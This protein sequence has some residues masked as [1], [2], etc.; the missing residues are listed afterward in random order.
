MA[1]EERLVKA[2]HDAA[3]RLGDV[4]GMR[5]LEDDEDWD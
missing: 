3:D 5:Y 1:N 2:V 4:R